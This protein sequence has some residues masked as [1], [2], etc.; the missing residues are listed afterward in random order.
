MHRS[1]VIQHLWMAGSCAPKQRSALPG[2]VH[3]HWA[4]LPYVDNQLSRKL[5]ANAL[6]YLGQDATCLHP[7][8]QNSQTLSCHIFSTSTLTQPKK[9][10]NLASVLMDTNEHT[11]SQSMLLSSVF[12][13]WRERP[14]ASHEGPRTCS[15]LGPGMLMLLLSS[16]ID[17]VAASV[18]SQPSHSS[19]SPHT[20][21]Y[22]ALKKAT[23]AHTNAAKQPTDRHNFTRPTGGRTLRLH[24]TRWWPQWLPAQSALPCRQHL[25]SYSCAFSSFPFLMTFSPPGNTNIHH[26]SSNVTSQSV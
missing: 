22:I 4:W 20:W 12:S 6:P 17:Y 21:H 14:A 26:G 23:T 19:S 9:K 18:A 10:R 2:D 8:R 25:S 7:S 16:V 11:W 5:F 1:S 13:S 15:W 24:A 3:W